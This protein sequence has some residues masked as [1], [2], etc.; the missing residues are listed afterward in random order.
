MNDWIQSETINENDE[1]I[2]WNQGIFVFETSALLNFYEYSSKTQNI[3]FEQVFKKLEQRLWIPSH[4]QFEYLKN[5]KA[6]LKK[7]ITQYRDLIDK[8]FKELKDQFDQIK[9]R[10]KDDEKHPFI[11]QTIFV[12]L[13][14]SILKFEKL[15]IDKVDE[16]IRTL[17]DYESN[18]LV[19]DTFR[20]VLQIGEEYSYEK[21]KEILSE[22]EFRYKHKIPPGYSDEGGK[23]K[24]GFQKYGDLIIWKQVVEFAKKSSKPIILINDDEKD[25]WWSKINNK[26]IISPRFELIKEM[27][28]TAG[29]DFWMYTSSKFLEKT[30]K[31]L[32]AKVDNETIKEVK[33]TIS[34]S[35]NWDSILKRKDTI[36]LYGYQVATC[37]HP[38]LRFPVS[39][40]WNYLDY[41]IML[42]PLTNPEI[43]IDPKIIFDL[44]VYSHL[45]LNPNIAAQRWLYRIHIMNGRI[46]LEI[47]FRSTNTVIEIIDQQ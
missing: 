28:D 23:N 31:M 8:N 46:H 1:T 14:S 38:I 19:L 6:T 5:R 27:K 47:R 44:E 43:E 15:F 30:N 9:S 45:L 37:A 33:E 34:N 40:L 12:E 25:D 36:H 2:L 3:I 13:E 20:K 21:M 11:D 41:K 22:G 29:V 26:E 39:I 24:H 10:T 42:T 17:S 32:Q 35:D 16:R 4:V 18:D 7:P